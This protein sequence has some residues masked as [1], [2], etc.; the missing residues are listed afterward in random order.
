MLTYQL[1]MEVML[2]MGINWTSSL[3]LGMVTDERNH[4]LEAF[5]IDARWRALSR[6]PSNISLEDELQQFH[7]LLSRS[8]TNTVFIS[9]HS[10]CEE[11]RLAALVKQAI[12]L[13]KA[14][15][16]FWLLHPHEIFTDDYK[17]SCQSGMKELSQVIPVDDIV[18]EPCKVDLMVLCCLTGAGSRDDLEMFDDVWPILHSNRVI[19][20]TFTVMIT[21]A[22][23]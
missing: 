5:L 1:V 18:H 6:H 7:I 14:N 11:F 3:R 23:I 2:T 4:P 8:N 10:C 20:S 16:D 15:K 22:C 19:M 12:V 21:S 17:A 13:T 9:G